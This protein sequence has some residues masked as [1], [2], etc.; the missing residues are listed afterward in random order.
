VNPRP[1]ASLR[2]ASSRSPQAKNSPLGDLRREKLF[3]TATYYSNVTG[4]IYKAAQTYQEEIQ[5]YPRD[6]RA[7]LDLGNR[8]ASLGEWEK[9]RE[10]NAE[11]LHFAPDNVGA[12]A[13]LV[14]SLLALQRFDEARQTLRQAQAEKADNYL[15]HDALYAPSPNN[16]E[17]KRSES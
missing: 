3:I 16:R 15:L 17:A 14:N 9:A 4:E 7:H 10:A 6:W 13:N 8:Y 12:T 1:V 2:T 5:A 11:S